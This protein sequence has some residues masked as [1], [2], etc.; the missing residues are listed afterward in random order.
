MAAYNCRNCKSPP[1]STLPV[2]LFSHNLTEKPPHTQRIQ[3]QQRRGNDLL[4]GDT[5]G[6][7]EVPDGAVWLFS[8]QRS[9]T[10]IMEDS[11]MQMQRARKLA[12]KLAVKLG[13]LGAP[14]F[15]HPTTRSISIS[16]QNFKRKPLK[17]QACLCQR[18]EPVSS[19][20]PFPRNFCEVATA[21]ILH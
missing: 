14:Y 11:N 13:L 9:G 6:S 10:Q 17:E 21:M 12:P 20:L 16:T 8:Q 2:G 4:P 1:W 3:W 5:S 18:L 19:H 15:G 7:W